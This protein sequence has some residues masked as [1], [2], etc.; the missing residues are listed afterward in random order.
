MNTATL[1]RVKTMSARRRRFVAEGAKS[2]RYRRPAACSA[3]R[4]ASSGEVSRRRLASIDARTPQLDAQLPSL[5]IFGVS[6]RSVRFGAYAALVVGTVF[7]WYGYR[8]DDPTPAAE[9]AALAHACPSV[10]GPCTKATNLGGCAV[11]SGQQR[12]VICPK[13]LYFNGHEFLRRIAE[14]AFKGFDLDLGADG[15]P[16]LVKGSLAK[17]RATSNDRAQVGVFGHEWDG[18]IKLP[19]AKP[20]SRTR[21]SVD[22]T[23]VVVDRSGELVA[24]VPVEVQSIDTTGRYQESL[25]GLRDGR[26]KVKS[27]VGLNW[28]NVNKRIIAQ[29]IKKGQMLQG[30]PL[31]TRGIFFVTPEA[32]YDK[33]ME[34]LGGAEHFRKIPMQSGSITFIGYRYLTPVL[35][36]PM[37][38][39]P[40]DPVTISTADMSMAFISP[41]YLPPA[42]SYGKLIEK[43]LL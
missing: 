36:Q 1:A 26:R 18:E 4:T 22:F 29:L 3:L 15:L 35:G 11:E 43:K 28:E 12:V 13:R 33:A 14:M 27:S 31:C 2:T 8:F 24:F 34:R 32:V 5:A 41:Q 40:L 21:Y 39:A 17:N 19:P 25:A 6:H 37:K 7:D 30:E 38:M 9:Q 16:S 23:L 42:G 10:P 20:G